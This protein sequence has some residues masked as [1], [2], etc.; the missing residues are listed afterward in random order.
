[1]RTLGFLTLGMVAL[2]T[3]TALGGHTVG[4]LGSLVISVLGAGYC[5]MR[6]IYSGLEAGILQRRPP[7]RR[8]PPA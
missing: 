5:S 8:H 6:G 2:I 7:G 3:S 1:M 4:T